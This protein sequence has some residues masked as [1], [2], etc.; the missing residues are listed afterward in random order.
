[1]ESGSLID[2]ILTNK[3]ERYTSGEFCQSLSDHCNIAC[4]C[5]GSALR[6]PPVLVFK[7]CLKKFNEQAFL[8]DLVVIDWYRIG[9]I[10]DIEDPWAYFKF[11]FSSGNKKTIPGV[12]EADHI[13]PKNSFWELCKIL[14]NDE[15]KRVSLEQ[16]NKALYDL[17]MNDKDRIEKY[18]KK[19]ENKKD[20][21]KKDGNKKDENKMDKNKKDKNKKDKNKMDNN[22]MD[23][24]NMDNNNMNRK[25]AP[26]FYGRHL[27]SMNTLHWDHQR[28]LTTASSH[29]S[30]ACRELL[31]DTFGNGDVV[32]AL[33]LSLIMAHPES[34]DYIHSGGTDQSVVDVDP[35][36]KRDNMNKYYKDGFKEIVNKYKEIKV[37]KCNIVEVCELAMVMS[38]AVILD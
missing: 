10:P 23:N 20:E 37:T 32:K 18:L 15:K 35:R 4:V 14:I 28:A 33:K 11:L 27:I 17:V 22:K 6:N 19:D 36:L 26:S 3:P 21:N 25:T 12:V 38:T 2:I 13:P 30:V 9:L 34:S 7:R 5:K 1:M 24:N 31:T 16:K 8:N 29:V